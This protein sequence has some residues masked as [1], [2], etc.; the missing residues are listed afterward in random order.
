MKLFLILT[1]MVS[2]AFAEEN[3]PSKFEEIK[4]Q[5]IAHIDQRISMLQAQKSC[6]QA[7]T[8]KEQIKACHAAHKDSVKKMREENRKSRNGKNKN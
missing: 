1:L 7:A 3:K 6:I 4:P 5:I 8:S 2:S